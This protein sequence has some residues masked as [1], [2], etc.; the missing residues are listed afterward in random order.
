MQAIPGV[1]KIEEQRNPAAWMLEVSSL[2]TEIQLGI[3]FG[4]YYKSTSLYQ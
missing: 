1:P 4:E 3:D 2:A